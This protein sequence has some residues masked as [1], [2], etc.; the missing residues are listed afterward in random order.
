MGWQGCLPKHWVEFLLAILKSV[1]FVELKVGIFVILEAST[2]ISLKYSSLFFLVLP[3][4]KRSSF[5][6]KELVVHLRMPRV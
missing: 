2:S 1:T 3:V 6:A 4:I 5:K